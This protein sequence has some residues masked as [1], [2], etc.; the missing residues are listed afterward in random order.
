MT[1]CRMQVATPA[2]CISK[3]AQPKLNSS[4][5]E[6]SMFEEQPQALLKLCAELQAVSKGRKNAGS[7][8]TSAA[9]G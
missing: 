9:A 5:P 4:A 6:E 7:V 1:R 3:K 2:G 8:Q